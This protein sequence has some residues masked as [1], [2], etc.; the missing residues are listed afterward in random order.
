ML[1]I[2]TDDSDY[3][4]KVHYCNDGAFTSTSGL[5]MMDDHRIDDAYDLVT[6]T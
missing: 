6:A 5:M 1:V 4:D 3:N 2:M